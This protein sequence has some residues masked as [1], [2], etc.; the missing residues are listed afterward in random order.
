M[1]FDPP[2]IQSKMYTQIYQAIILLLD[3][4][5]SF[6]MNP[7]GATFFSIYRENAVSHN[8]NAIIYLH[9]KEKFNWETKNVV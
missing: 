5:S 7:T 6:L 4:F 3:S 2:R 1:I 8:I 9:Q